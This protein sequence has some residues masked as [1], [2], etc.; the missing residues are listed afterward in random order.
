MFGVQRNG[1]F[2]DAEIRV[3]LLIVA[4][5]GTTTKPGSMGGGD[6][7]ARLDFLLRYPKYLAAA[8]RHIEAEEPSVVVEEDPLRDRVIRYRHPTWSPSHN[9]IV[10]NLLGRGL[11]EAVPT[12]DGVDYRTIRLGRDLANSIGR[13]E[14]WEAVNQNAKLVKHH[15]DMNAPA[16]KHLLC[17]ADAEIVNPGS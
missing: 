15:F 17:A 1:F 14:T 7:L 4:F 3:L 10:G 2:P 16:L 9:T 11:I 12:S 6:K 13:D 5:S 8:L